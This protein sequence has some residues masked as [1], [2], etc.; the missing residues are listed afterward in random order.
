MAAHGT[1]RMRGMSEWTTMVAGEIKAG[2]R[3]RLASGDEF[4]VA[5]IVER[6]LGRDGM[7]AFIEDTPARWHSYPMP[8]TTEVEVQRP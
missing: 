7:S 6:F 1:A 2:D 8:L 4:Q 3:I 5:K